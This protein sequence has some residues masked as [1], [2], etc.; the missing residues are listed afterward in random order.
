MLILAKLVR[1]GNNK[2][3]LLPNEK[4]TL[5]GLNALPGM[6]KVVGS[7]PREGRS[8]QMGNFHI[9]IWKFIVFLF[10]LSSSY[11]FILLLEYTINSKQNY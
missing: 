11:Y 3:V 7:N 5:R 8:F 6:Q 1:N 9:L 4:W 10:F 2:Y